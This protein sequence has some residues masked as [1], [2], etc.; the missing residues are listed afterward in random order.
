MDP[1]LLGLIAVVVIGL[2]V[3]IYGAFHDRAKNRRRAAEM[4]APPPRVIPRFPA[5]AAAPRYL[6]E[7]Q[8]RLPAA[9]SATDLSR[10]ERDTITA[11]LGE[12]GTTS[13]KSGYASKDFVTDP[14]G[15]WSVLDDAAVLVC[16]DPVAS[17]R[18]LL[19]VLEMLI[20]ARVPLAIVV[21]S[22]AREVR[23]TLEVNKIQGLLSVVVVETDDPADRQLVAERSGAT[24]TDRAD[25]QA[26]YV[27]A[28]H[29]GHCSRW[30]ST[31]QASFL[32]M[33]AKDRSS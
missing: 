2:G 1:W 28:E 11:Q 26:G 6:S 17:I 19:A 9:T 25:R 18:E 14:G 20:L 31:K 32:I 12:P 24:I 22:M 3:I 29:L 23:S 33:S 21:P 16:G 30:V 10:T 8:A 15:G 7:L 4:L 27:L 5:E 13:I